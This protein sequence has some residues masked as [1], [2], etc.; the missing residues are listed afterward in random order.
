MLTTR[1][2]PTYI[3]NRPTKLPE[4]VAVTELGKV[5]LPKHKGVELSWFFDDKQGTALENIRS[6]TSPISS[7]K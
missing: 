6:I 7:W 3:H 2:S 5:C 1:E 4:S